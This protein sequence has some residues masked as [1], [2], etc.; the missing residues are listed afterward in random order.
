[1]RDFTEEELKTLA[2][3]LPNI[4]L[5][6]RTSMATLYTAVDRLVPPETREKDA[7]TDRSAAVFYQSYYQMY[8]IISNLTDAGHLFDRQKFELYDDDIVGLCRSVCGEVEF[9]FDLGGVT[10]DF[11]A[12]RDS[13]IISMDAAALRKLLLNL[14]SNAVKYTPYGGAVRLDIAELPCVDAEHASLRIVVTD[15]GYGMTQEFLT[16][17]FDPFTRAESS[18]TNKVQGTGLGM[19]ITKNIV[20]LMGGGITVESEPG[21]GSC[22]QVTLSLPIDRNTAYHV[23]A[24]GILLLT[25]D[26]Q[27]TDNVR[28]MTRESGLPVFA[29]GSVDEAVPLLRQEK[30]DVVLLSGCGG[31]QLPALADTLRRAARQALLIFCTDHAHAEPHHGSLTA[32]GVDGVL[33]RPLFLSQLAD[34]IRQKRNAGAVQEQA[35][36]S[37]L[38]GMRFL[39]AEDNSLNAEILTALME[40]YGASCDIYPDGAQLAEAFAHVRA[41][42][43]QAILMD[44][45]M[46]VMNGLDAARAIRRSKNPLGQTI[47]II[48]M[49]AN[50]FAEDV[51]SCLDAGMNAHISKP[52]DISLLESILLEI[53]EKSA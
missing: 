51:Q 46:P 3:V 8:R 14:L 52:I 11:S 30:A 9:L 48:A 29:A 21:R 37:I 33:A 5:Q 12:D 43:Y 44:M 18:T 36:T 7:R 17:I 25:D 26:P 40:M 24:S 23:D 20:D 41:G 13:R 4:A 45:Q 49:T 47:P 15:N 27:F 1:M 19:A 22:F 32:A 53:S 16:H 42:E 50:A 6:L 34:A 38:S 31:Q 35:P 39:C 2:D 28:A 10:L